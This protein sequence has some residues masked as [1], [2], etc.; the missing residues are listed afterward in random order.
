MRTQF[1]A[2]ADF[3]PIQWLEHELVV[4]HPTNQWISTPDFNRLFDSTSVNVSHLVI[5][6]VEQEMLYLFQNGEIVT[7]SPVWALTEAIADINTMIQT[8]SAESL[9]SLELPRVLT[10]LD[11]IPFAAVGPDNSDLAL[12]FTTISRH[13]EAT[14][15]AVG[16]GQLRVGFQRL[17]RLQANEED[18][19]RSVYKRL[20]ETDVD[21][22][23]YGRPDWFPPESLS[24]TIHAGYTE[25]FL[26]NWF[27]VFRSA[28]ETMR[29]AFT[30][31]E[32][33]E[34][35]WTGHWTFQSDRVSDINSYLEQRL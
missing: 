23:V 29:A 1:E 13:I 4:A 14:A 27:V 3:I 8:G 25:D 18:H 28:N 21:V 26:Q 24:M 16:E 7:S 12:L 15:V 35:G 30:A 32:H 9:N 10:K 31:H 17:S 6:D 33:G 19:T 20:A 34:G 5:P 2:I 11:E 22:H